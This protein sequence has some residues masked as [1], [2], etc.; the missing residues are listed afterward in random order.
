MTAA[1]RPRRLDDKTAVIV[2]ARGEVGGAVAKEL[3]AQGARLFL[4]GRT[5]TPVQELAQAI[6]NTGRDGQA[7]LLRG[8][9]GDEHPH[10]SDHQL[11]KR[12]AAGLTTTTDTGGVIAGKEDL[13]PPHDLWAQALS[14]EVRQ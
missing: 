1:T 12:S 6:P 5:K 3:A 14:D 2:G 8:L 9:G 10:R 13:A 11:V 4:S 7:R